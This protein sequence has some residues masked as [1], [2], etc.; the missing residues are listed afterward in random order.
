MVKIYLSSSSKILLTSENNNKTEILRE[1]S[2]DAINNLYH[3]PQQLVGT[4]RI[5]K[6]RLTLAHL[7]LFSFTR[8]H[9]STGRLIIPR[10]KKGRLWKHFDCY[11]HIYGEICYNIVRLYLIVNECV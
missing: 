4:L 10:F 2:D 8:F 11:K 1:I 6:I 5:K 3:P 7:C 9:I